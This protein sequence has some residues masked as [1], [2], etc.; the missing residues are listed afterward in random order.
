MRIQKA[1]K[2]DLKILNKHLFVESIPNLHNQKLKEQGKGES[3]WLIAWKNK[4]PLG[5]VQLRLKKL[6]EKGC[7][8]IESLGVKKDF[9]KK[10]IGTRLTKFAENLAR[11]KGFKKIGLSVEINNKFLKELYSKMGYKDWGKGI[12]IEKWRENKKEL[13]EECNYLIKELK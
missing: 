4:L 7:A 11:K 13:R 1:R 3:L 8:H 9:R 12:I 5:H 10:G 2:S 6:K